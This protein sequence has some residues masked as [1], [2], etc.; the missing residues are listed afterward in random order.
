[1]STQ[2]IVIIVAAIAVIALLAARSGRA[3]VTQ[4]DRS[5]CREKDSDD[6]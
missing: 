3:R 5:A 2:T 4:I 1:M 6:A